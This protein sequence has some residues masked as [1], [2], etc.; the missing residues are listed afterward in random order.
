MRKEKNF[1][2]SKNDTFIQI[3]FE[4]NRLNQTNFFLR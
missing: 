2:F 4:V 1:W 3:K